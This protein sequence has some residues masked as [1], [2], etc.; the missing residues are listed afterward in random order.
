VFLHLRTQAVEFSCD[1][2]VCLGYV[3]L[4][5]LAPAKENQGRDN[6]D[7]S[8]KSHTLRVTENVQRH[9]LESVNA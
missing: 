6:Q 4:E 9:Q 1:C 8:E 7:L 2:C 3:I 5:G